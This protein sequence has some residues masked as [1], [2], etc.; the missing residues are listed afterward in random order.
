LLRAGGWQHA[1]THA[2]GEAAVELIEATGF[3]PLELK[4]G[5]DPHHELVEIA[6]RERVSLII[7]GSRCLTGVRALRS[8]SER[9]AHEAPCSVLILR[10]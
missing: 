8:T 10:R 7:V 4:A 2:L 6:K 3:E 1:D 5:G 9:V